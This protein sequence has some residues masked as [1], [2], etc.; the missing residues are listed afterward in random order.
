MDQQDRTPLSPD[1]CIGFNSRPIVEALKRINRSVAAID[2]FG[3][4]DIRERADYLFS[5]LDQRED[6]SIGRPM[7]RT[8]ADYLV[9]LAEVMAE[10][11]EIENVIIG[12]GLDDYP[13]HWNRLAT[14]GEFCGNDPNKLMILRDRQLLYKEAQEHNIL[15]P[16]MEV[17]TSSQKT[18]LLSENLSFPIVVKGSTGGGGSNTSLCYS[19]EEIEA[20]T[21]DMLDRCPSCYLLEFLKGIPAS[22]SLIGNGDQCTTVAINKQLI[23]CDFA[24]APSPFTYTGN[25]TPLNIPTNQLTSIKKRFEMLGESLHLKGSNGFDFIIGEDKE[26]YL[27]ELNPRIQGTLEC[28]EI[29]TEQSL[30]KMHLDAFGG[31]LP[32]MPRFPYFSA[33][34]VIF[35]PVH[36]K[37]PVITREEARDRPIPGSIIEPG[38]PYCSVFSTGNSEKEALTEGKKKSAHVLEKL[39]KQTC[40]I[41]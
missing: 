29:A 3:D 35:S 12:S 6:E 14:L 2:Y 38:M 31:K 27:L 7:H 36:A 39:Q 32:L 25:T 34:I 33:K 26:P 20:A 4:V 21:S 22:I 41:G 11:V 30:I 40:E 8:A 24:A 15:T 18:A 13:E 10:E 28:I 23:G 19:L 9:D 1:L 37:V 17:I 16:K 5:I